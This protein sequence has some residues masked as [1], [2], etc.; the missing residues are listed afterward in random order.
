M[1]IQEYLNELE[2]LEKRRYDKVVRRP[3]G[4]ASRCFYGP[5]RSLWKYPIYSP[6]N[7]IIWCKEK[8]IV[9]TRQWDEMD[10]CFEDGDKRYCKVCDRWV[11][12]A[13]NIF[14]FEKY[15]RQEGCIAIPTKSVVFREIQEKIASEIYL[16]RC[17]QKLRV[18][19][20]GE[21]DYAEDEDIS[22]CDSA[23]LY[24]IISGIG[25][26]TMCRSIGS[27][28]SYL[29]KHGFARDEMMRILTNMFEI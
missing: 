28:E 9:C 3:W 5:P 14:L 21:M 10:I 24:T 25:E 17:I 1:K 20:Q 13:S 4:R 26:S 12:R 19:M 27:I 15:K 18:Y 16:Y 22:T 8:S 2:Y 6:I 11:F 7:E 23:T 29:A